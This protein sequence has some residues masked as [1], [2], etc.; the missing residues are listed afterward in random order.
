MSLGNGDY[1]LKAVMAPN[2]ENIR[3]YRWMKPPAK[4]SGA[5]V[6]KKWPLYFFGRRRGIILDGKSASHQDSFTA[7]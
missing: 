5:A 4:C 6:E 2:L 7:E 1:S 3:Q